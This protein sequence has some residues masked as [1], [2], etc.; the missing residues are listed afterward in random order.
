MDSL[1]GSTGRPISSP[2]TAGG[3]L[4]DPVPI[5]TPAF[6]T[7]PHGYY[8]AMREQFGSL[9]P[10]EIWPGVAATLVIS[11]QTA[12]RILGDPSHFSSDPRT[13][14]RGID[15]NIPIMPMIEWRP[16]ALRSNGNS[17]QHKRYRD[18]TNDALGGVD[19]LTLHRAVE[20]F[21]IPAINSFCENGQADL[22]AQYIA[23][24]TFSVLNAMIGCPP[25]I[26]ER[27]AAASAALFEGVD[28]A[29][30][31]EMLDT[32]LLELTRLKRH[33]PGDDIATRLIH[34]PAELTDQEM[35]HQLVTMYSAGHELPQDLIST[36][37]LLMM[38][39]PR[40]IAGTDRGLPPSTKTAL[41][42]IMTTDPPLA[43]YLITYPAQPIAVDEVWLPANQPVLVSM[44][45]CCSDPAVY[46]G[47]F[48]TNS[49]HLGWGTGPH[50]CPM[51][52]QS[53]SMMIAQDVI[54]QFFDAL[55]DSRP[56]VPVSEL[57]WRPGP[58]HRAL[59]SFPIVF[60]PSPPLPSM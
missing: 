28:T 9:V 10:V 6:A 42:E 25:E 32:A 36:T 12:V 55:P 1:L 15:N 4:P 49:S 60:Q 39:D 24:V 30:V 48:A 7:D 16:N 27:V 29:T 5:Y 59:A 58:F 11:Y 19:Q 43:N 45:A 46:A 23:P 57:V 35:I 18:A 17:V 34:H 47:E 13:W 44:A 38:T 22:L 8:R 3:L 41:V 40:Y 21:A 37:M 2:L 56:A 53:I 33:E 54:D 52:A 51:H 26:G 31:N 50:T 20:K 14:Q